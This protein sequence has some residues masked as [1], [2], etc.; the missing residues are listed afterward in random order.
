MDAH[1]QREIEIERERECAGNL[2]GERLTKDRK[3]IQNI[4]AVQIN[5]A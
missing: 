1:R 3:S 5:S 4:Q 2:G